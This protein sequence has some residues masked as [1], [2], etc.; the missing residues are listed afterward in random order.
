MICIWSSWR[1]C[2]PTISCFIKIQN[3]LPF[4]CQ[5]TQVFLEKRPLNGCSSSSSNDRLTDHAAQSVTVGRIYAH[6]SAMSPNNDSNGNNSKSSDI[7]LRCWWR[8]LHVDA[9]VDRGNPHC[10]SVCGRVVSSTEQRRRWS[11]TGSSRCWKV[12][13]YHVT[14]S[15]R[16]ICA[17]RL[18]NV[19]CHVLMN[20]WPSV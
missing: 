10:V 9:C 15:T 4:W 5:L 19:G 12:T 17:G 11:W 16:L 13:L 2:R 8:V 6:S 3:G 18:W 14:A 20:W 7:V 1:H